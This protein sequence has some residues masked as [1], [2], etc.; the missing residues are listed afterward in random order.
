MMSLRV[1]IHEDVTWNMKKTSLTAALRI[2]R[3]MLCT[4]LA[5]WRYVVSQQSGAQYGESYKVS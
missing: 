3:D 5:G 1:C 4:L 2:Y